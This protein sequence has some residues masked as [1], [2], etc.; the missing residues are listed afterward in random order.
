M[1][2]EDV[3]RVSAED[4]KRIRC[5]AGENACPPEDVGGIPGYAEFLAA[6]ADPDH[7]EHHEL[8]AWVGGSFDP[9]AFDLDEVNERLGEF[10]V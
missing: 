6:V 4:L 10:K 1:Q 5:V 9:R 7:E 2:V 3:V 8:L